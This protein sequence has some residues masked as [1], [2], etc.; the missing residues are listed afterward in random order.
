MRV[1]ELF[2]KSVF[3]DNMTSL[4]AECNMYDE[5]NI[6]IQQLSRSP[7]IFPNTMSDEEIITA[8]QTNE[9]SIYF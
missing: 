4:I 8:I 7:F 6:L 9:Y 2:E 1:I 3:D 5:N